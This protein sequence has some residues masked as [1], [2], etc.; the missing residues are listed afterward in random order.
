MRESSVKRSTGISGILTAVMIAAIVLTGLRFAESE[1]AV[2][3]AAGIAAVFS[4]II[5]GGMLKRHGQKCGILFFWIL[6]AVCLFGL[7]LLSNSLQMVANPKRK[8]AQT[9]ARSLFVAA[10]TAAENMQKDGVPAP[11]SPYIVTCSRTPEP[12]SLAARIAQ[13]YSDVS[14]GTSLCR[15]AASNKRRH[16]D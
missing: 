4:A 7:A 10:V 6:P 13:Y 16:T 9:A 1:P 15:D 2:F 14:R 5:T 12:D 3:L 11:E 8:A